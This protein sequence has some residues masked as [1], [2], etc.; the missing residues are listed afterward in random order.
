MNFKK[1]DIRT[2]VI[3]HDLTM[4]CAAWLLAWIT[5]FNFNFPYLNWEKSVFL[6]PVILLIQA[7]IFL[8]YKLYRG[9]WRFASLQDLWNIIRAAIL[10]ALCITLALFFLYRLEGI[11]RSILVLYPVYL[12]FLLGGSRLCYRQWKEHSLNIRKTFSAGKR[13]LIIGGG[14][15]GE[16]LIRD[17]IRDGTYLPVGIIDDN[18]SLKNS[19]IHGVRVLGSLQE[20]HGLVKKYDPAIIV[21]AIPSATDQ[22]MQRIIEICEETKL[23]LRTLPKLNDLVSTN[24]PLNELKEV[25]IEDLLGRERVELDWE[26]IR[27]DISGKIVFVTG[28]GGSIGSELCRQIMR[29]GPS[30][31]IIFEQSEFNLYRIH[32]EL[33]Q[34]SASVKI[35]PALGNVCDRMKIDYLLET[36]KP[37][38]IFHSAAYKHVPILEDETREAVWNNVMGTLC[39]ANSAGK[40]GCSKFILISTDKA[41]NPSNNLG[42]TKRVAEI[43]CEY[44]NRIYDTQYITV[45]F[46]NVLGSDGSVVPL[47]SEQIK[48]GGPVTVTHPDITRYFMTIKEA[49]QLI[50]QAC[51][52]GKGGEI[53]VLDMGSPV[54]ITFL[55]EQMIRLS[56]AVAGKDIRIEFIG[57][58]PGEKLHEEL[59]YKEE[60][61]EATSHKKI[62]LAKHK[63][64]DV[65]A[66]NAKL[67]ELEASY[68]IYDE[69]RLK[70]IL[71]DI[72]SLEKPDR[73]ISGNIVTMGRAID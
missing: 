28:G 5:R 42:M 58:R 53:Y 37:D 54:K 32:R 35:V 26:I 62:H 64:I 6:L 36:Y 9:I 19:E 72:I 41:V 48:K 60:I 29:L 34:Y 23:P 51:T 15:A 25:S 22:Q 59:F 33:G 65:D 73:K 44:Q 10:G 31:L 16:T 12:I 47:F 67:A 14:R 3:L 55:A 66:I 43:V 7:L 27:A 24:Y 68:N 11:P 69:D 57:L 61:I 39:I 38:Y 30:K 52:I 2:A 71:K 70:L 1:I 18:P 4:V 45:R 50:L 21:I 63:D 17:I 8:R 46:G 56:G 40:H 49:C 13:V 20:L